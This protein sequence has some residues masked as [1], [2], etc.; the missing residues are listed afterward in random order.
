MEQVYYKNEVNTFM[1]VQESEHTSMTR[2]LCSKEADT[3]FLKN[4]IFGK[5]QS[6]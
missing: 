5:I 2:K 6:S 3:I 1:L 4:C